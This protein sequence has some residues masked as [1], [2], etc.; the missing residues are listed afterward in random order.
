MYLLV[1][2]NLIVHATGKKTTDT[3]LESNGEPLRDAI[4][5]NFG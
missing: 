4:D 1:I 3:S 5:Y 2:V